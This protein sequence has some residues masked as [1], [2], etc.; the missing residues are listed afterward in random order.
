MNEHERLRA[1]WLD[2]IGRRLPEAARSRPEWPIRADHCFGRVILD[3]VC[4]R[5]WREVLV[6]PAWRSMSENDLRA[7]IALGEAVLNGDADLHALDARSLAMRGK[8]QKL[9]QTATTGP[10]S[11]GTLRPV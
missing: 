5:P 4:G 8:P 7:A 10:R 9:R 3:A 6:P 2:L 11:S 1:A